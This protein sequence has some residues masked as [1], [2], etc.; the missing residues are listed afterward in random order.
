MANKRNR[1]A[2]MKQW[3][4]TNKIRITA[5]KKQYYED[6][7]GKILGNV[8]QYQVNNKEKIATRRK[9]YYASR[10]YT[11]VLIKDFWRNRDV[12]DKMTLKRKC[13]RIT[14][15]MRYCGYL[16]EATTCHIC[17]KK[18]TIE[19]HHPDYRKPS[20]IIPVCHKCHMTEL[21]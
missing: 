14:Q 5:R 11:I 8:K 13:R 6:N 16:L 10:R 21:H 15:N 9:R 1:S 3:Y 20:Y 17:N 2:Y 19:Y 7:R 4:I 18:T 12:W